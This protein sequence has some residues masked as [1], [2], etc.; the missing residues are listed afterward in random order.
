MRLMPNHI[1]RSSLFAPVA[2]GRKKIHKNAELVSRSDA[3][4]KFRGEQFDEVQADVWMQAMREAGKKPL[5]EPVVIFRA[6]FLRAI[7]RQTGKYEYD[8]LDRAMKALSFAMLVI[9]VEKGGKLN[10][11]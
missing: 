11:R 7:G 3:T 8:W 1:A 9:E 4:I 10:T 5:G 6:V 2:R